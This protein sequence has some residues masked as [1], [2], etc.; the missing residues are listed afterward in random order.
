[1]NRNVLLALAAY[2]VWGVLPV[3]WKAL[4]PVAALEVLAHRVVWSLVLLIGVLAARRQWLP[5]LHAARNRRILLT[6]TATALVL[7]VNWGVYIWAVQIGRVVETSLG[8][9]INPLLSVSLGVF[10]L[11]ERLRRGQWLAV[12]LAAGGVIWLTF[13]AGR[14]PWIALVLAGSFALYGLLRKTANVPALE[15][16]TMETAAVAVP[17]LAFLLYR[18]GQGEAAFLQ[19]G[20]MID[21]LLIGAGVVTALPLLLF[22][23]AA[24][25]IPLSLLGVLQYIAPTTQFLLGLLLYHEPFSTVQLIGFALIWA[26]LL[27]FTAES[28]HQRRQ[29][30]VAATGTRA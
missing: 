4:Q 22:G 9:F 15:G 3:F 8:Y 24:R 29:T 10:L 17:A 2:A 5:L 6:S 23:A 21:A 20:P 7:M 28:L 27:V 18:A 16:L 25:N 14:L 12:A 13:A 26:A 30:A 19:Q 1:M 11:G